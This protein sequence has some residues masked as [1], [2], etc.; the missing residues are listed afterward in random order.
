ME[1]PLQWQRFVEMAPV[2]PGARRVCIEHRFMDSDKQAFLEEH[3]VD[4]YC[5]T[6]DDREDA[7]AL[8][9]RGVDGITSNDLDLLA[10]LPRA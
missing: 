9:S 10:S 4:V 2:D 1:W 6:V 5:W 7:K 3:G 8:V